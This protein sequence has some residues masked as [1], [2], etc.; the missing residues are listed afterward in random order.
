M[1]NVG[2]A[3]VD[4]RFSSAARLAASIARLCGPAAIEVAGSVADDGTDICYYDFSKH[5][6]HE[7]QS[8]CF[9]SEVPE[10]EDPVDPERV[11]RH[12]Q[13]QGHHVGHESGPPGKEFWL[14]HHHHHLYLRV[15]ILI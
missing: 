15:L 12:G 11:P 2:G 5:H 8:L 9:F 7:L 3:C 1:W 4:M 10:T 14:H 6:D 13:E